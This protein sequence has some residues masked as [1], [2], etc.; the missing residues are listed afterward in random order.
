[1]KWRIACL[2]ALVGI[3]GLAQDKGGAPSTVVSDNFND[4]VRNKALWQIR[5][6]KPST[7]FMEAN[8]RLFLSTGDVNPYDSTYVMWRMKSSQTLIDADVLEASALINVPSYPSSEADA[9]IRMGLVW[10]DPA[11]AVNTINFAV[12]MTPLYKRL[13]ISYGGTGG[14]G[15]FLE[16]TFPV[17][18][19][20]IYLKIRYSCVTDKASFWWRRPSETVWNRLPFTLEL[21]TLW[22]VPFNSVAIR[23]SLLAESQ[24]FWLQFDDNLYFDNFNETHYMPT[25]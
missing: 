4:G 18:T 16:Y 15:S 24:G 8:Q 7:R 12:G 17:D 11:N 22:S 2:S 1:M 25:P 5:S 14:G 19:R 10:Q 20:N 21:N 3:S 9:V 23:S 6:F 13:H